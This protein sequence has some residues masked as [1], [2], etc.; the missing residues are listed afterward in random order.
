MRKNIYTF[1]HFKCR[2]FIYDSLNYRRRFVFLRLLRLDFLVRLR[3]RPAVCKGFLTP[4][5]TFSLSESSGALSDV[6][7]IGIYSST[8]GSVIMGCSSIIFKNYNITLIVIRHCFPVESRAYNDTSGLY[9]IYILFFFSFCFK[10]AR[11]LYSFNFSGF[12]SFSFCR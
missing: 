4:R 6:Y 12:S 3:L 10:Y 5:G 8:L 9:I 7:G 11:R 1:L 2:L